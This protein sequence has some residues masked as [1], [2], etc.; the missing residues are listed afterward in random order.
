[1]ATLKQ[2]Q[3][4][5]LNSQ[6]STGP[7]SLEG[8]AASSQNALKSGIDARANIMGNEDPAD[9]AALRDEYYLQFQPATPVER[10]FVDALIDCEW[11]LRRFR[12]IEPNIWSHD[13]DPELVLE[14]LQRR[15]NATH[16]NYHNALRQLQAL[17]YRRPPPPDPVLMPASIPAT[18]SKQTTKPE[19]GFVPQSP[20]TPLFQPPSE[21]EIAAP[22]L[23]PGQ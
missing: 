7:R 10:T 16:R 1:M 23:P 21:P 3:A 6:K 15:I 11:L 4:N 2:I 5:R 14:R 19:I 17:Q 22:P 20:G 9:L 12:K 13:Q 18:H 8:K